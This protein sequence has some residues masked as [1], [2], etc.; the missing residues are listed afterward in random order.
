MSGALP[1]T[2]T[3]PS[4]AMGLAGL[5]DWSTAQPFLNHFRMARP[6]VGRR[7]G[8]FGTPDFEE[9]RRMG[10]IDPEGWVRAVPPGLEAVTTVL[11]TELPAQALDL[12]AS[13]E[14]TWQGEGDLRLLGAEVLARGPNRIVFS[15]R[16]GPAAMVEL[17]IRAVTSGP[18]R[19]IAIV[20]SGNLARHRAG[21]LFRVEWL[22]LVRNCRALRF[23]D[24]MRTNDSPQCDWQDRP[25]PEDAF[26][27]WRGAPVEV[28]VRLANAVGADPWFTLPHLAGRDHVARFATAVCDG[29]N[30]DLR[31]HYEYSNEMWNTIFGQSRWAIAQA[32]RR[33]PGQGDGF[34]QWYAARAVAMADEVARVHAQPGAPGCVRV[35]STHTHWLGLEQAILEAPLWRA[36]DPRRTAPWRHF[37]AYAV[38][39]Y[40]DGGMGLDENLPALRALIADRGAAGARAAL[41]AQLIAGGW[42][43]SGRTVATLRAVW[44]HHAA[45]AWA[46][47]LK[48]LMYEGGCHVTL[49]PG[50]RDDP[51]MLRF[52]EEFCYSAEMGQV[53][54]AALAEWAT[55]GGQM[56]NLFVECDRPSVHGFWGLRRHTGDDN[57]RSTAVE[58]W[59]ESHPG[60]ADRA[61]D[62][63]LGDF[64]ADHG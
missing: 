33:W 31:A 44:D 27:T 36:E 29:L 13:Y 5:Y 16:P 22:E 60:A 61:E 14:L 24:W 12:A 58:D 2:L 21:D 4:V 57:P 41:R 18:I 19:D 54:T 6:W 55:A 10:A 7:D 34:V 35:I 53:Q 59:N 43:D 42:R 11:L 49:P 52:Y 51:A 32:E 46:R 25:R 8:G 39:G 15:F 45:I 37:D 47:G 63:F 48:L 17:Q 30:P 40:V 38:S 64:E 23:M 62:C 1:G 56:F 20:Q 9:L 3:N 28:M 50:A 26:Y